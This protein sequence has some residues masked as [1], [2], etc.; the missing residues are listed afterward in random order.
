MSRPDA[1]SIPE[2]LSDALSQAS[3]LFRN[4][5][6]LAKAE[7]SE[8][9]SEAARGIGVAAIGIVFVIPAITLLLMAFAAALVTAGLSPA[10]SCL[11]VAIIG[12]LIAGI[13][14]AYGKSRL[15]AERLTP[16]ATLDQMRRDR[17]AARELMQ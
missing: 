7:A 9:M 12:F 4:E 3:T 5:A 13:A 8:K 1:R 10:I 6:E 16:K 11:L 2:L 14:V 17:T 15:T